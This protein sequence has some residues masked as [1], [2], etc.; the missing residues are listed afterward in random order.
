MVAITSVSKSFSSKYLLFNWLLAI[1]LHKSS[2]FF[3]YIF[4]LLHRTQVKILS[5]FYGIHK[6]SAYKSREELNKTLEKS[7]L[8]KLVLREY[9]N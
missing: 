4:S 8:K 7:G 9:Y 3:K 6:A 5:V 2:L 1:C